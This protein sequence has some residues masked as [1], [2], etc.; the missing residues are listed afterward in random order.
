ME[1]IL[2]QIIIET[3]KILKLFKILL[4][5]EEFQLLIAFYLVQ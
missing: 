4:N 5:Y 2:A 1:L 3:N